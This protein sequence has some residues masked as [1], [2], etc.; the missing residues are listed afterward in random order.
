MN[1]LCLTPEA[2][3]VVPKVNFMHIFKGHCTESR[4]GRE[5]EAEFSKVRCKEPWNGVKKTNLTVSVITV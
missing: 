5:E 1:L 3:H 2:A 4:K